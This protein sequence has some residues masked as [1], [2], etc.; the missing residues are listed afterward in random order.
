VINQKSFAS[1]SGYSIIG[2]QNKC[3]QFLKL[4]FRNTAT[5]IDLD[6]LDITSDGDPH[7]IMLVNSVDHPIQ[8]LEIFPNHTLCAVK[9]TKTTMACTSYN[10]S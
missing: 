8:N 7:A 5:S 2:K 9:S 6:A 1:Q 4:R 3:Q 10:I